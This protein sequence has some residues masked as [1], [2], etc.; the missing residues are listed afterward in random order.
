MRLAASILQRLRIALLGPHLLKPLTYINLGLEINLP[1]V[2]FQML[3]LSQL[4]LQDPICNN[5]LIKIS[6]VLAIHAIG[7]QDPILGLHHELIISDQF[8]GINEITVQKKATSLVIE[9]VREPN[10]LGKKFHM[11][12]SDQSF[13]I[14]IFVDYHFLLAVFR[15]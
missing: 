13:L 12:V 15:L 14:F 7:P 8:T 4:S 2:I 1:V 5:A 10:S 11:V 9:A 6:P 3:D